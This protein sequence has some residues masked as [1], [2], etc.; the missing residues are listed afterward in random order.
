LHIIHSIDLIDSFLEP[1]GNHCKKLLN[2]ATVKYLL[3]DFTCLEYFS[4]VG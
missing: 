1:S 4:L 3:E 2:L